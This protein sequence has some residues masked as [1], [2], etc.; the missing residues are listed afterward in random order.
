MA[1]VLT[2]NK[3]ALKNLKPEQLYRHLK[4]LAE[5]MNITVCE[6]SFRNAGIHVRSGLCK[7]KG[8]DYFIMNKDLAIRKK[9]EL[10]ADCLSQLPHEEIYVLPVIRDLFFTRGS[11]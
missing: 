2:N 10:L 6:Q 11:H 8:Q 5:K 7:I 4:E 1:Q 9:M 3:T